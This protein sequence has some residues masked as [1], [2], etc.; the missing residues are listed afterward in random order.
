MSHLR[1]FQPQGN[2]VVS[3]YLHVTS[4]AVNRNNV[5]A[6]E[7]V[8]IDESSAG[9][10]INVNLP[11]YPNTLQFLG[12]FDNTIAY[13]PNQV[14]VVPPSSA[15][16]TYYDEDGAVIPYVGDTSPYAQSYDGPLLNPGQYVCQCYIPNFS[17]SADFFLDFVVPSLQETNVDANDQTANAYRWYDYSTY[18]PTTSS[19]VNISSSTVTTAD[20]SG[21]N[22]FNG[23]QYWVQLGT[24]T[25]AVGNGYAGVF[26]IS[27]SYNRGMEVFVDDI[28]VAYPGFWICDIASGSIQGIVPKWPIPSSNNSDGGLGAGVNAWRLVSPMLQALPTCFNNTNTV[29]YVPILQ[30]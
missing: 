24:P 28:T 1:P 6:G 29:A 5:I 13:Y 27:A 22:I 21:F 23:I 8:S 18:Y 7:G 2:D 19:T 26:S 3:S 4:N 11:N 20:P 15:G 30:P 14:M 16:I 17:S 10:V 12:M 25:I 9:K